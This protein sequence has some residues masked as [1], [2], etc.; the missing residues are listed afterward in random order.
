MPHPG[1]I[2]AE[3]AAYC[4][5]AAIYWASPE[6]LRVKDGVPDEQRVILQKLAWDIV[7]KYP[8]AGVAK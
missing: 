1:P 8:Y 7:S 2:A 6:G 4:N 3:L 5:Y